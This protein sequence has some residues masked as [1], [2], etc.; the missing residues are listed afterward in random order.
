MEQIDR[1]RTLGL[2]DS[3]VPRYTSYPTA[4]IFSGHRRALPG[5]LLARPRP[6]GAGL[7][8]PPRP[9]LRARSAWFCACQTQR[10][11]TL[12]PVESYVETMEAELALMAQMLP[13]GCP[14]GPSPL[15]RGHAD[16]PAAAHDR[17]VAAAIRSVFPGG[18]AVRVF[19][20]DGS[21][22]ISTRPRSLALQAAGMTAQ[23]SDPGLCARGAGGHRA[24]PEL[25]TTRDC[26]RGLRAAGVTSLTPISS[27]ACRTRRLSGSPARSS[28]C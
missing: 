21:P 26:H 3:R 12:S 6:G 13:D 7:G 11:K 25:E 8:L 9:F 19:G 17:R 27:T 23:A 2:F 20:R 22:T 1:L 15:G 10:T 16:S 4:P 14:H 24:H 18:G 5:R 28:R